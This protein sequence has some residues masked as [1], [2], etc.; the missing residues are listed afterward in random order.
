MKKQIKPS[1]KAHLIRSAF[2]VLLLLAICVIPFALAQ[3]N[4]KQ[5]A[6]TP[7]V[8]ATAMA[9]QAAQLQEFRLV[10]TT[11]GGATS[12]A[13][14]GGCQF[15]VTSSNETLSVVA[16]RVNNPHRSPARGR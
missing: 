14:P 11:G 5:S 13:T 12:T 8:T 4:T 6:A 2:Y 16:M 10:G 15:F 1:I 7:Y 9:R 3:R